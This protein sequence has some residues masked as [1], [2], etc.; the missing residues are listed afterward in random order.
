MKSKILEN[1]VTA[2]LVV[3]A[4]A[5]TAAVIKREFLS[6]GEMADPKMASRLVPHAESLA[7]GAQILGRPDAPV[8]IVEF[9]DF[10][11]PFCAQFQR[12]LNAV[13]A[14]HP[15]RL[16]VVYRHFPLDQIHPYARSAALASECAGEQHAFEAYSD[17]LFAQQDSIGP[18]KS[19][20]R[21]AIEA[22]VPD[23]DDFN[24]CMVDKRW[25]ARVAQD[26]EMGTRLKIE[27]TPS[28]IVNGV[29]I[30]GTASEADIE[31]WVLNPSAVPRPR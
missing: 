19:W 22:G 10:Q 4:L 6:T 31:K 12:T 25:A 3:C 9:S 14:R 16:S 7:Q 23:T 24:R 8:Q 27:V 13:R 21:F 17:L 5:I 28:F 2:T 11:C 26:I 20:E 15:D 1:L 18:S 30:P 29:L